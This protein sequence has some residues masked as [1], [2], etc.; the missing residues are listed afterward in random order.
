M[1]S[2]ASV[3]NPSTATTLSGANTAN[4]GSTS[5]TTKTTQT[6]QN[7]QPVD[8]LV[9]NAQLATSGATGALLAGGAG[10]SVLG[11][12]LGDD[13]SS[14]FGSLPSQNNTILNQIVQ[15]A[16]KR[17][18]DMKKTIDDSAA[19][20]NALIDAQNQ[21]WIAVKAEINN[22]QAAVSTGQD[23]LKRVTDDLL[24]LRGSVDL[25]GTR[26]EDVKLRAGQFDDTFNAIGNEADSG[27]NNS[28]VGNINRTDFSPNTIE[29]RNDTALGHAVLTGT[30]IAT[31]YRIAADDGTVWI[32]DPGTDTITHYSAIQGVEQK[33][34]VA[35]TTLSDSTS[36]RTGIKL[37]SYDPSSNRI[38]V[39]ITV[40]PDD[41]PRTVSG[42]L[43]RTGL[44]V[45]PAWFYD[46]L[47]TTAG[48]QRAYADIDAASANLAASG[49]TL[50]SAANQTGIDQRRA[51]AALEDL[52]QQTVKVN[53]DQLEQENALQQKSVQ[54]LTALQTNLQGL[55]NTQQNYLNMLAG[56]VDDP[57]SQSLINITV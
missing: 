29:Y 47:A 30:Y 25:A 8:L 17:F 2:I 6:A 55:Q 43:Q 52:T 49:A 26:G 18:S 23:S 7:G 37:D 51:D 15:T 46:G 57:L 11:A 39:D 1:S 32:P 53:T 34:T 22:A 14:L 9:S 54:Q 4:G 45:M 21:A 27:G 33:I 42:T 50:Q 48:R 19:Q 5:S 44:G 56:A 24:T 31:D 16:I 20:A 10:T 13:G 3:T 35:G 12:S 36:T 28:L 38:T 41:P 40:N